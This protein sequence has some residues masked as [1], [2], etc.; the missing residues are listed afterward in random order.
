MDTSY[1]G[2]GLN[3][4]VI[5][6]LSAV[7]VYPNPWKPGSGGLHD[8]AKIM[9]DNLPVT[10]VVRI[11]TVSGELVRELPETSGGTTEWDGTSVY[12]GRAASG[13]Y[14]AHIKSG[15]KRKIVKFAIE[16]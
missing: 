13:V 1:T 6:D 8:R 14:F 16:R 2:I 7:R 4:L 15:S 5:T 12:G 10:A 9:F 3:S 11:Y